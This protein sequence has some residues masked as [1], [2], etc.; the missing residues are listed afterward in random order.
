MRFRFHAIDR[1]R[2][3]RRMSDDEDDSKMCA[4]LKERTTLSRRESEMKR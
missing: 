4:T 2:N 1:S 3:K